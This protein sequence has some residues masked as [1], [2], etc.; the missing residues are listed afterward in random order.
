[1]SKTLNQGAVVD[2]A[3]RVEVDD[4][5]RTSPIHLGHRR[6]QCEERRTELCGRGR[7]QRGGKDETLQ[8]W[9]KKL[10]N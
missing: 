5:R 7:L 1:M 6:N 9:K 10:I 8:F 3:R 2:Q 4:D